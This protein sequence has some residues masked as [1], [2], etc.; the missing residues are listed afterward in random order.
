MKEADFSA[1]FTSAA[2]NASLVNTSN[3]NSTLSDYL[4]TADFSTKFTAAASNASLVNT[5][6]L[7]N[8]LNNYATNDSV[9]GVSNSLKSDIDSKL[10][11]ASDTF[12]KQ[13]SDGKIEL[14]N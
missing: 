13:I 10:N 8:T 6:D 1:K 11:A 4:K 12:D 5:N 14:S 7:N 9:S 2:S 3:L